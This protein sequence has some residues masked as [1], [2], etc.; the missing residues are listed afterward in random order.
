[1]AALARIWGAVAALGAALIAL[2]VGAAAVPWVAVPMVAA[3][4]AQAIVAVAALRGSRWRAGLVLPPLLLPTIVWLAAIV[5]A[6]EVASSLPMA[7]LLAESTLAL[8][9]A[10]LLL[11]RRSSEADSRTMHAVLGL[12]SSAAVVATI[13]TVALAGTNAGQFAQPHGVHAPVVQE[14]GSGH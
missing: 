8:G 12:L 9:A 7:P 2:A 6:P 3:G 4:V 1:M 13:T 14:H 10:S 5:A 11:L